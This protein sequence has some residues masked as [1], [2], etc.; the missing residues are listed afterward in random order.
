MIAYPHLTEPQ[1]VKTTL[2]RAALRE[3]ITRVAMAAHPPPPRISY[4]RVIAGTNS[5]SRKLGE[6][7]TGEVFLGEIDCQ[8]AAFKRLRLPEGATPAARA[9]LLR[10][11]RSE[12]S[13]LSAYRHARLVRLLCFAEDDDPASLFPFVLVFELLEEGSLADWLRGPAGEPPKNAGPLTAL[14]RVTVALGAA[15][16]LAYLHGQREEGDGVAAE[17]PVLHRD[18]KSANV[19]LTRVPGGGAFCKSARLRDCACA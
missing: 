17:A 5:F 18:I 4:G 12:L 6:G 15:S 14:E 16:A 1:K 8:P 9:T 7:A 3:R 13:V 10:A 19:G 2:G 11:F